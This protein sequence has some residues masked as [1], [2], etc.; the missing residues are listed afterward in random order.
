MTPKLKPEVDLVRLPICLLFC[1]L[2][3]ACWPL[4]AAQAQDPATA[5]ADPQAESATQP[6]DPEAPSQEQEAPAQEKDAE[7]PTVP[8]PLEAVS[9]KSPLPEPPPP[10]SFKQDPK[11][12]CADGVQ[13]DDGTVE[14]GYGF[15]SS[16]EWGSFVQRFDSKELF[17]REV[18]RVCVCFL[19][20]RVD[21]L[22][23]EVV[24]HQEV[25]GVPAAE[26]Y[27]RVTGHATDLPNSS[28]EAGRM[29]PVAIEGVKLP[30]GP[31]YIGVRWDPAKGRRA[32]VCSSKGTKG[33]V[34]NPTLGFQKDNRST[35]WENILT[36]K[37]WTFAYHQNALIRVVPKA[38]TP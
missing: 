9:E 10:G 19:S 21:E 28:K 16:L 2:L 15:I 38:K 35:A 34:K 13:L 25:G 8:T 29:Y 14:G 23:F 6:S 3:V 22:E 12:T 36:T 37:D 24:F 31:S 18:E 17:D 4:S 20:D 1:L 32:F 27:A 5:K 30:N 26:P 7:P 33:N 11:D